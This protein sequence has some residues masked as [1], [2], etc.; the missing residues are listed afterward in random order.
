MVKCNFFEYI[1]FSKT[2]EIIKPKML[3][4]IQQGYIFKANEV[5][6]F[7]SLG[8]FKGKFYCCTRF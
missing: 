6:A 1:Q 5:I 4:Q 2:R 7:L 3:E 8:R